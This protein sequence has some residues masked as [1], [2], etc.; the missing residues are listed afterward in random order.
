MH[1]SLDAGLELHEGAVV[2]DVG[3]AALHLGADRITRLDALPGIA[4]QLLHAERDAV[5]FVIDLDDPHLDLLADGQDVVGMIDAAPG[6]VGHVQQA[7]DTA[8]IDEGAVIGDVLHDAVDGL[9]LL[10]ARHQLVALAGAGLLEHG[11]ARND[12]VAAPAIHLQDLELL[13]RVH[14]RADVADRANI[15]LAARQEGNGAVEIDGVAALDLVEDDAGD[16]LVGLERLFE[17]APALL[18]PRLVA[19]QHRLA[20]RVLHPLE[21]DLDLVADLER[22]L[23]AGAGEFLYRHAA[24]GL[25]ADVDN[26]DVLLDADH[27]ALDDRAFMQVDAAEGFLQHCGEVFAGGLSGLFGGGGHRFSWIGFGCR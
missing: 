2:G 1:Q 11:A 10:E 25:Q 7:V 18:A 23:A 5:G 14:E 9:A 8:E 20:Q 13:R 24:F 21:I 12:D 17:T 3:D 15:D 19:R 26:G 4:L 22:A 16:L 27:L 6:D